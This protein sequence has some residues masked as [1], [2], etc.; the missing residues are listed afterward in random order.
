M[1]FCVQM[2][3]KGNCGGRARAA[4]QTRVR[5]ENPVHDEPLEAVEANMAQAGAGQVNGP[6]ANEMA[7]LRSF[8]GF[9][10]LFGG[11]QL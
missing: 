6:T 8:V 9:R 7:I 11:S 5:I 3:P 4:A 10:N 1:V 2:P